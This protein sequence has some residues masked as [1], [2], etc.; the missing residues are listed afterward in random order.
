MTMQGKK[1]WIGIVLVLVLL[2]VV[3]LTFLW[4]RHAP[5][6][7]PFKKGNNRGQEV[8]GPERYIVKR[9]GLDEA[10][11]R[12]FADAR[13]AHFERIQP[14]EQAMQK[15]RESVFR[16][17]MDGTP[18]AEVNAELDSI[19]HL[20]KKLD[21]LTYVHFE[22]LRSY[23]S[24]EQATKLKRVIRNM[25]NQPPRQRAGRKGQRPGG[26]PPPQE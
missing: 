21:S 13:R 18:P 24:D 11:A 16:K 17:S 10:Q 9:L 2:N 12:K 4:T 26:G 5:A 7:P 22:A 3:T 20:H 19:A 15:I 8:P 25:I 6:M 23:C 1:I 14:L